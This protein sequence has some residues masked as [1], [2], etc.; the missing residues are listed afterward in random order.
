MRYLPRVL[1]TRLLM[2]DHLPMEPGSRPIAIIE[3]TK[4]QSLPI[5]SAITILA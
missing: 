3:D 2:R 4:E 5:V 1:P